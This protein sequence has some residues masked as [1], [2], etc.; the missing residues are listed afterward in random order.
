MTNLMKTGIVQPGMVNPLGEIAVELLELAIEAAREA[1]RKRRLARVRARRRGWQL[2]PGSETPLWNE[3]MRQV[4]ACMRVRGAQ[5]QLARVLGLPRQ[6]LNRCL[7][8]E[9]AMLDAERTLLLLGW[10]AAQKTGGEIGA[11]PAG[12]LSS[13]K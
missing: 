7:T 5:A 3:L 11:P 4:R 10:L 13:I 2:Q 1:A 8:A 6:R 9:A 12:V